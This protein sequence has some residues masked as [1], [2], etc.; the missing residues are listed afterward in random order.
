[1]QTKRKNIVKLIMPKIFVYTGFLIFLL[2]FYKLTLQK[3]I[4]YGSI[5][6]SL[7]FLSIGFF[8]LLKNPLWSF[9]F[10]FIANYF[11]MGIT[12]YISFPGG[13]LMDS[14]IFFCFATLLLKTAYEKI[15]WKKALTPLTLITFLWLFF[16]ILELLNPKAVPI[17]DWATRVRGMAV[18]PFFLAILVPLLFTKYKYF[19]IILFIWSV[20]TL[21]AAF[22]G[23]WQKNHGFD[24][25]ELY[26]LYV[27][28]G[29]RTHLINTGIR[30]FSFFT[31]AGNYG[32]SM[33]F[34]M[35]VFF[36]TAFFIRNKWMKVYFFIAAFAGGYGMMISG[37]RGAIAVPFIGFA[38]FTI[39]SKN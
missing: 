32:S 36:T 23:Y 22:K 5:I 29:A 9:I 28:G 4:Y 37:T 10:L 27:G 18:Y 38:V 39:L 25:A 12:R 34:S 2:I 26:W 7:P 20:L 35:V 31:D 24:S 8:L 6:A 19:R 11:V 14:V 3:G 21:L 1:M 33:G 16:C 15:E 30:F 13:I 17:S